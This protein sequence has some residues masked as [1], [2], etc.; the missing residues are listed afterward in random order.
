MKP[1][2]SL[3]AGGAISALISVLHVILVIKPELYRV[4]IASDQESA[5][6][7]VVEQGSGLITIATIVLAL[8]FAT[9][10]I[11]AFSGA[12]LI[13]PLPLQRT[14]LIIIGVI[15]ILRA[16]FLPSEITMV[17]TQGYPFRFVMFST[18]SLVT[19]LLYLIG[20]RRRSV[21]ALQ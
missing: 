14:V 2:Q 10:A 13:G 15:Y 17:L 16:F 21:K 19:G 1:K 8:I 4:M 11:Y 7:Q 9:W 18:V 3:L 20:I 5:L 12:G 6:V